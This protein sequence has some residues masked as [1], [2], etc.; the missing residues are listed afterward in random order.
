MHPD[1]DVADAEPGVQPGAQG[2]ERSVVRGQRTPGE[3]ERRHEESAA[4]VEHELEATPNKGSRASLL[5][6]GDYLFGH[7]WYALARLGEAR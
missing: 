3:A 4:R 7:L 2:P 6:S 1:G 5:F